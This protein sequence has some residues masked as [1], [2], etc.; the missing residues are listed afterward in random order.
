MSVFIKIENGIIVYDEAEHEIATIKKSIKLGSYGRYIKRMGIAFVLA[1]LVTLMHSS[2][3]KIAKQKKF[4]KELWLLY[5][6]MVSLILTIGIHWFETRFL[7]IHYILVSATGAKELRA[8]F[9]S[10]TTVLVADISPQFKYHVSIIDQEDFLI[11]DRVGTVIYDSIKERELG[12]YRMEIQS[13]TI[14]AKLKMKFL[15]KA[16]LKI[17]ISGTPP[18]KK[19]IIYLA[20]SLAY[21]SDKATAYTLSRAIE[22]FVASGMSTLVVYELLASPVLT[23]VRNEI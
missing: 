17:T 23:W 18:I 7:K 9:M 6:L 20:A 1:L 22:L 16:N 5:L 14:N 4:P 8:K 11:K 15:L 10:K 3:E 13:E 19:N 2:K 21:G 12:K